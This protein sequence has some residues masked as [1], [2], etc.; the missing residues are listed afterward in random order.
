MDQDRFRE[1][2]LATLLQREHISGEIDGVFENEKRAAE[3]SLHEFTKQ[4]W[5][6]AG[7]PEDYIDNWHIQ[8]MCEHLEAVANRQILRV[9]FNVPPGHYKSLGTQVFFPAWTWAQNP[10]P[11]NIPDFKGAVMPETWRGPGVR[12]IFCTH[13]DTLST[14]LSVSCRQLIESEW[15]KDRWSD[16][17]SFRRDENQKTSFVNTMGGRRLAGVMSGITGKSADVFCYDDPHDLMEVDHELHRQGVIKFWTEQV[18]QRIRHPE[19]VLILVMQRLHTRDLTGYIL[20]RLLDAAYVK[21]TA[22]DERKKWVHVCL[23][24]RFET[25]HPYPFVTPVIR[26]G[27]NPPEPW[28]D[29]R[30]M[31]GEALWEKRFPEVELDNKEMGMTPHAIAGQMQQRPAAREGGKFKRGW[32]T[33]DKFLEPNEV[34]AA[35]R[36]VRHWDLAGS[37]TQGSDWTVGLKLG[38][39]PNGGYVVASVI[40]N[41]LEGH[42]VR[43]LIKLTASTDGTGCQ[44]SLPQDP[45]QAGKVQASDFVRSLPG[46]V[47]TTERESGPKPRRADPVAAQASHGNIYIVRAPWTEAFLEEL[48]LFPAAPNDD[49]VD[50]LSG[51]FARFIMQIG[52]FSIGGLGGLT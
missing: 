9:I 39:M 29:M 16:R 47:V 40:R 24:A 12:F 41:Q 36:W 15:Y 35:T 21:V 38:Q 30:A 31:E 48:C 3:R 7:I 17:V 44:I 42:D 4:G 45:G 28:R 50:A 10:N 13:S 43:D 5:K 8:M 11:D 46:Y 37:T 52:E 2:M 19:S 20:S 49:Q 1:Q 33:E 22:A 6:A 32:F 18:P 27:S 26:N 25:D 51:A 34:P 14:D 23:P